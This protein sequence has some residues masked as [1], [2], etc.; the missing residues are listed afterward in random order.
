M[1]VLGGGKERTGGSGGLVERECCMYDTRMWSSNERRECASHCVML[2]GRLRNAEVFGWMYLNGRCVVLGLLSGGSNT[3]NTYV[4]EILSLCVLVLL[5]LA[6]QF[7]R[8][9]RTFDFDPEALQRLIHGFQCQCGVM[10][11]INFVS[12][13]FNKSFRHLVSSQSKTQ[14]SSSSAS[15]PS[16]TR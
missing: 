13:P 15:H 14:S 16:L 4:D 5:A 7:Q 3:A 11:F 1:L 10:T 6:R 12:F 8:F 2:W 9:S